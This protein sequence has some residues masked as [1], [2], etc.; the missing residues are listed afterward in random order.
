M[1]S[2]RAKVLLCKLCSNLSLAN[3]SRGASCE[4]IKGL[5]C[6]RH[7]GGPTIICRSTFSNP[8]F[9][10]KRLCERTALQQDQ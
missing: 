8:P 6:T 1:I 5:T 2:C 10:N 3:L 7:A 4:R 9:E